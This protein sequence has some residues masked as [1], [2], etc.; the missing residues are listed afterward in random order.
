MHTGSLM[1]ITHTTSSSSL[2][3]ESMKRALAQKSVI[4]YL[5]TLKVV[6]TLVICPESSLGQSANSMLWKITSATGRVS[7]LFGTV[8][9]ESNDVFEVRDTV[10]QAYR[11]ASLLVAEYPTSHSE[12]DDELFDEVLRARNDAYKSSLLDYTY[13]AREKDEIKDTLRSIAR[14]LIDVWCKIGKQDVQRVEEHFGYAFR[15]KRIINSLDSLVTIDLIDSVARLRNSL[16][17]ARLFLKT[18][19]MDRYNEP[20]PDTRHLD[21]F[22]IERAEQQK[23]TVIYLGDAQTRAENTALWSSWYLNPMLVIRDDRKDWIQMY[24]TENLPGL[25]QVVQTA[26]PV[27]SREYYSYERKHQWLDK[28]IDVIDSNTSFIAVSAFHLP[29]KDGLIE[30]LRSRGAAVE[31]VTVGQRIDLRQAIDGI[32]GVDRSINEQAARQQEQ[33][34]LTKRK[35]EEYLT[36]RL[37]KQGERG[38]L[39]VVF[40]FLWFDVGDGSRGQVVDITFIDR[41]DIRSEVATLIRIALQGSDVKPDN[42]YEM[43]I[44]IEI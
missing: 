7:H 20:L 19:L 18:R 31:A 29:G 42:M 17:L 6:L 14:G 37:R 24:S 34:Q 1:L 5:I 9:S 38:L 13:T 33:L 4:R 28:L 3:I 36:T 44:Q 39:T 22:L 2:S 15:V 11:G 30:L 32:A 27:E 10:Y 8:H 26:M 12:S 16:L 35:V 40:K 41:E 23:Q 25:Y 43:T 21:E